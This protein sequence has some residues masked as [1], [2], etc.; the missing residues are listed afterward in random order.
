MTFVD[1]CQHWL[2][3]KSPIALLRPF[4]RKRK[5]PS[6]HATYNSCYASNGKWRQ[7]YDCRLP[8][9]MIHLV[10]TFF[11]AFFAGSS[12]GDVLPV[13]CVALFPMPHHNT[14]SWM[15]CRTSNDSCRSERN[16][17]NVTRMKPR[18]LP[19]AVVTITFSAIITIKALRC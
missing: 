17:A 6:F 13:F 10:A 16:W 5:L 4:R 14:V 18:N 19:T 3:N 8:I 9:A 11:F 1:G 12:H 7:N 15:E 2:P